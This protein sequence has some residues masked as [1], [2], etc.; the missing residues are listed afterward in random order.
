MLLYI[1]DN[2][3]GSF[4]STTTVFKINTCV[5]YLCRNHR[6]RERT[7]VAPALGSTSYLDMAPTPTVSHRCCSPP[8]H[9]SDNMPSM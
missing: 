1:H 7:T 2:L 3:K 8:A 9:L 6:R 5:V 4:G